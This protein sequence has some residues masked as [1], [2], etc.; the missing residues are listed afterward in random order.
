MSNINKNERRTT[1]GKRITAIN[2]L[3]DGSK[4]LPMV[5]FD[6]H[7]TENFVGPII[8]INNIKH[9]DDKSTQDTR[10]ALGKKHFDLLK[11]IDE[12][13]AK[14]NY[15]KSGAFGHT[16]K[17]TGYSR[18]GKKINFALKVVAYPKTKVRKTIN[19]KD[20]VRYLS[21]NEIYDISRPENAELKMIKLLSQFVVKMKNPHITL[22]ITTFYTDIIHFVE[23]VDDMVKKNHKYREKYL[24]FVEKYK[25]GKLHNE[26]SILMSEWANCGDFG[27]FCKEDNNY[28]TFTARQWKVF[29]F[30]IL[31]TLAIIQIKYPSFRHNDLKPN[32]VLVEKYGEPSEK[33]PVYILNKKKYKLPN[34]GYHLKIW[35]FDFACIPGIVDNKKVSDAWTSRFKVDPVKDQY[36]DMHYFFNTLTRYGFITGF[37]SDPHVPQEVKDFV[38]RAVPYKYQVGEKVADKGRL[39]HRIEY[40]TPLKIISTDPFFDEFRADLH[41]QNTH[42][43]HKSLINKKIDITSRVKIKSSKYDNDQENKDDFDLFVKMI[44]E[45]NSHTRSKNISSPSRITKINNKKHKE[46]LYQQRKVRQLEK[47]ILSDS[48]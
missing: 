14:L 47:K 5:D 32:N 9:I 43:T 46:A 23:G 25:K 30:Q 24:E 29:F 37:F 27:R 44:K 26:A 17:G 34:I 12:I 7:Q 39:L 31:Y 1:V 18:S 4:I 21:K 8:N 40:T 48:V 22:P 20:V 35:D 10:I 11:V 28:Q 6:N 19:G 2:D 15:I 33:G 45:G 38:T 41:I 36:Y 16:F 42:N 13:N 3:I